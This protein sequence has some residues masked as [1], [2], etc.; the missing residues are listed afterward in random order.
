MPQRV[1]TFKAP[2]GKLIDVAWN[3]D[4]EPSNDVIERARDF[5]MQQYHG[6][7]KQSDD[8]RHLS[9]FANQHGFTVTG[10]NETSGHNV[11][12]KHYLGQAVDIRVRDKSSDEVEQ[13]INLARNSG[14][15]V[16]DE[17]SHPKGQ[18]VWSGPHLHLE[19]ANP[20]LFYKAL[21]QKPATKQPAP[22]QGLI[23]GNTQSAVD[24]IF[25][26]QPTAQELFQ[27]ATDPFGIHKSTSTGIQALREDNRSLSYSGPKD[28]LQKEKRIHRQRAWH[29]DTEVRPTRWLN[30]E[31]HEE[32]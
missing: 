16:V 8:W 7:S 5:A 32:S 19:V 27:K 30:R 22:Q 31:R 13:M 28:C 26:S 18:A 17:R 9:D 4:G 12:S 25:K 14:L 23:Q 11:G 1:L 21:G 15:K 2:D 10:A 24:Q 3:G 6:S 29:E 20:N